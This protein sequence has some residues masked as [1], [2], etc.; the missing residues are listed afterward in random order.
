MSSVVASSQDNHC[1][2]CLAVDRDKF[3]VLRF[4]TAVSVPIAARPLGMLETARTY[5]TSPAS[6]SLPYN[7][8]ID[9]PMPCPSSWNACSGELLNG[10]P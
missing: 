10:R 7:E 6:L 4:P 2:T 5:R 1:L 3:R 9:K 8:R